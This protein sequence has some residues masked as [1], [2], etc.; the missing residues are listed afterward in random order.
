MNY[1]QAIEYLE[2]FIDYEKLNN[3]AYNKAFGLER[4]RR[5]L[6]LL[7]NPQD[8]L[9]CIHVAGTKGKGSTC[10]FIAYILR[11][12]GYKV[13]LYTSPHLTDFRER[14]RILGDQ[15]PVSS[16]QPDKSFEGMISRQDLAR[17][18]EKIQKLSL[19]SL[20]FFE[21]YTALAFLYFKQKRVDY[22]V[23]ETGMGG[24]LDATNVVTPLA[25][26]ITPISL[27]HTQYLGGTLEKIAAEKAG[28][29]KAVTVITAPQKRGV[30]AVIRKRCQETGARLDEIKD[31]KERKLKLLGRHQLINAEVA[32]RAVKGLCPPETIEKG[33][34]NTRWP[35]RCEAVSQNP[36][37]VLDGAQNAA[38]VEALK[39]AVKDNFS[40][41][42]LIL[43]LGI[44][45]DKDIKGICGGFDG[46]Y[47]EAVLTKS[48]NPRAADPKNLGRYFPAKKIYITAD[49]KE[50]IAKASAIA[51][52]ED[53]ILATGS[54][55]VVGE[56]RKYYAQ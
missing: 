55:F 25:S 42:R 41:K 47:D 13:G 2:S 3:Y 4:I 8:G 14:I 34:K 31:Y 49:T 53:L 12:A 33:L 45:A 18:V 6:A 22:A 23:L 32:A 5:L 27:E 46:F 35:G 50:A 20:T 44:S 17:L 54:L 24:R 30:L 10:A 36:L 28:I 43:V 52:R 39:S 11:Q 9:R 51:G 40:Y 29:I 7:G 38:S 16:C 48:A 21:I 19:P 56:I 1:R 37:V 15:S 26:V